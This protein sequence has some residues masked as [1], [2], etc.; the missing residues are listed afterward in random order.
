MDQYDETL[1]PNIK[2]ILHIIAC[3]P[4]SV[5]SAEHSFLTLRRFGFTYFN[6]S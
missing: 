6:I 4:V 1:Y 5:V 2:K 3:L